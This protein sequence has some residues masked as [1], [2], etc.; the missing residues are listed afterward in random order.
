[1]KVGIVME[2]RPVKKKVWKSQS[3]SLLFEDTDHI[4]Q[5][6]AFRRD[7]VNV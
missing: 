5:A 4:E 3:T 7:N 2:A 1:M 6:K